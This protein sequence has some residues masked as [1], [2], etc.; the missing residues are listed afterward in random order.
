MAKNGNGKEEEEDVSYGVRRIAYCQEEADGM[1]G[2]A[3]LFRD[4]FG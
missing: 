1:I 2:R 3:P 4:S